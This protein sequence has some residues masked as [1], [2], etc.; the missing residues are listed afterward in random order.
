MKS[1]GQHEKI[2]INTNNKSKNIPRL[3]L[4]L[5]KIMCTCGQEIMENIVKYRNISIHNVLISN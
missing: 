4:W 5:Y 1:K 2:F 3:W